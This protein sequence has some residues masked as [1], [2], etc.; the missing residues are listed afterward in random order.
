M[1]GAALCEPWPLEGCCD[2]AE[3]GISPPITGLAWEAASEFLWLATGQQFGNC[4]VAWRPCRTD[5]FPEPFL[6]E[7]GP[8]VQPALFNGRWY[9]VTCGCGADSCSCTHVS[10]VE[11]PDPI[12]V[13]SVLVDGVAVPWTLLGQQRLLRTDGGDWPLC[14]DFTVTGGPG[15]WV[16]NAAVGQEVPSLGQMA[17]ATLTCEL[18]KSCVGQDCAL[19]EFV[20]TVTRQG[21]T[22]STTVAALQEQVLT[23]LLIPDMFIKRYN[24][25]GLLDRARAYSPDWQTPENLSGP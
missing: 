23:G 7:V 6:P 4:T 13:T 14:Q 16:V 17:V 12:R 5:C 15:T 18:A 25:N 21:I 2:F 20:T 24:P 8:A 10:E 1:Q 3:L 19:P 11:F 22:T 9:N